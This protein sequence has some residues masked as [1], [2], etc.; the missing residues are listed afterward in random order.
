MLIACSRCAVLPLADTRTE[1]IRL[2][3]GQAAIGVVVGHR[4]ARQH[5]DVAWCSRKANRTVSTAK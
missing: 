2:L 1:F 5:E 4:L 3:E